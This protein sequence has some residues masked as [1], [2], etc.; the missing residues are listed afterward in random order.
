ME[1]EPSFHLAGVI[2]SKEEMADFEGPLTLI[3]MLLSKNKVEIRDIQIAQILEQYLDYLDRMKEMDLEIASEFVQM[4]AHLLYIKTR[5]LLSAEAETPG[6]LELLMA[7]LEQLRARDVYSAVQLVA[8][9]FARRMLRGSDYFC[10]PP[11][12][13]RTAR[14]Y[15][16]HHAP[17]ELLNA[18]SAALRRGR[19]A[20]D[21]AA[22]EADQPRR[23]IPKRIVYPV[24]DKSRE[25]LLRLAAG[26][27]I[28]IQQIY[29]ESASRSE[30]VAGFLSI[31][32]LCSLGHTRMTEEDGVV[33]LCF[34]GG[35]AEALAANLAAGEAV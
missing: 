28:P 3:L 7:S 10:K 17:W 22:Q 32:E 5:M 19:T 8:P 16:Y 6:E 9:A 15:R 31:L 29:R 11:E 27:R 12:A 13:L 18:L 34:C 1:Q 21:E 24:R 33:Y 23:L 30:L 14:E 20:E 26:G 35:D 4:A 2:R 25:L